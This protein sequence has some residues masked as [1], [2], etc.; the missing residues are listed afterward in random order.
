MERP[1]GMFCTESAIKWTELFAIY[2]NVDKVDKPYYVY[3]RIN[4]L[5][6]K[7]EVDTG[8]AVS[9]ISERLYRLRF[10]R[11]KLSPATCVLKTSSKD[12]WKKNEWL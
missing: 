2:S 1:V 3:I 7:M 12:E 8:A 6:M 11:L 4:N 5:W 9:V 10:H